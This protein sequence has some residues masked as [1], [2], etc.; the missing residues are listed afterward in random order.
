MNK[1]YLKI[2]AVI[3]GELTNFASNT[4]KDKNGL[5]IYIIY[6]KKQLQQF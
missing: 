6:Y 1:Y 2:L 5:S 3:V 4:E